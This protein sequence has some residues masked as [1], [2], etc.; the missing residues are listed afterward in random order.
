MALSLAL[1]NNGLN[2]EAIAAKRGLAA[3]TIWDHLTSCAEAGK[4]IPIEKLAA[5]DELARIRTALEDLG[6]GGLKTVFEHFGGKVSYGILKLVRATMPGGR[7]VEEQARVAQEERAHELRSVLPNTG[8]AWTSDEE[9]R[10]LTLHA[11]G[12]DLAAMMET[13]GRP[14][15]AIRSRLLKLTDPTAFAAEQAARKTQPVGTDVWRPDDDLLLTM[16]AKSGKGLDKLE[17]IMQRPRHALEARLK[18][19]GIALK[20]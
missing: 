1:L 3:S 5:P 9:G 18:H 19:L 15:A 20:G 10:L 8:A 4:P 11:E 6:G 14:A 2:V 16:L 7:E 13:L 17:L 12:A